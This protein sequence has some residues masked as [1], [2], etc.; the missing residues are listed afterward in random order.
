MSG[1]DVGARVMPQSTGAGQQHHLLDK[2]QLPK[3]QHVAQT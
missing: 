3:T 1:L 2:Q